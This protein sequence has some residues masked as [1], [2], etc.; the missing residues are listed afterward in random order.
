MIHKTLTYKDLGVT[1]PDIYEQMGYGSSTDAEIVN[2][3]SEDVKAEVA[4]ILKEIESFLKPELCFYITKGELSAKEVTTIPSS[5]AAG[6]VAK[7]PEESTSGSFYLTTNGCTLNIGKIIHHQLRGSSLFAFFVCTAGQSFQNYLNKL[8]EEGDMM[9]EFTANA[10]GSVLAEKTADCMER[11]LES[12]LSQHSLSHTNRFSPGYC[13]WHV[14]EQQFLFSTFP[15]LNP[16]GVQLTESSLMLPIKSVSGVI[17]IG[18]SVKKLEYTCGL[19]DFTK[20]Y[21]RRKK[22]I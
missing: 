19:C 21:K 13:G 14:R 22:S 7:V 1:L 20:C 12:F 10:I 16:C 4:E 2:Y 17:G 11:E 3:V 9:K 8:K 5:F 6:K 15:V 18:D